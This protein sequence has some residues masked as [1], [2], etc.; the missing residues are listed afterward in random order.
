[1]FARPALRVVRAAR[2]ARP[3][4]SQV[5]RTFTTVGRLQEPVPEVIAAHEVRATT[6]A[7]G[8]LEKSTIPV[9]LNQKDANNS[10][11]LSRN[12]YSQLPKTMQSLSLMDKVVVVT[13]YVF[14]AYFGI[15]TLF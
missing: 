10:G 9:D 2:V 11:P 15:L 13:G 3:A 5:S 14:L 6:Y 4:L 1:M 7:D 12:V 8:H